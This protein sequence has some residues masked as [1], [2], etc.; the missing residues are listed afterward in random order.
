MTDTRRDILNRLILLQC[1]QGK[2]EGLETLVETW[3]K[4][5]LYYIRR[6][7]E[8]EDDA[9]DVMQEVWLRV[10]RGIS[11]LQSA[12]AMPAWLYKIAHNAA[13]THLHKVRSWQESHED[14]EDDA[15][16]D[17]PADDVFLG[18]SAKDIH[19]ALGQLQ[20]AEREVLTL[21]FLEGYQINEIAQITDAPLGTV[22]S[23]MKRAKQNLRAILETEAR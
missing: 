23:R 7:V 21:H 18:L 13:L 19:D 17:P 10:F 15:L 14:I 12:D 2:R 5:L 3:Q 11:S 16:T 20:L 22:K 1:R 6:M 8:R 4:P 9:L